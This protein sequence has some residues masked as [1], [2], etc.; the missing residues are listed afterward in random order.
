MMKIVTLLLAIIAMVGIANAVIVPNGD[1]EGGTYS[2]W[3]G[4]IIPIEWDAYWNQLDG[5][6]APSSAYYD[7]EGPNGYVVA[8]VDG[9]FPDNG[10]YAVIFSI[11]DGLSLASIGFSPGETVTFA[12]DIIDLI[13]GGG[14]GGAILKMESWAGGA[15]ID[16]L[17]V[18]IIGIAESWANFSMDYTIAAGAEYIKLVVGTSTG[19]VGPNPVASS[20]GFDNL[21]LVP[22]PATLALLVLGGLF[23]RRRSK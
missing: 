4:A 15:M 22:E 21:T 16:V 10:G 17:E 6:G 7:S 13:E 11:G 8:D 19:W 14:G 1:F 12:A 5:W 2:H 20:Y 9:T 3:T 18:P 23:L